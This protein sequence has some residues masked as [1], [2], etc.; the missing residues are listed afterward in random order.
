MITFRRSA[1]ERAASY[2]QSLFCVSLACDTIPGMT[3]Y[4][5]NSLSHKTRSFDPNQTRLHRPDYLDD[6]HRAHRTNASPPPPGMHPRRRR[7]SRLGRYLG[8]LVQTVIGA[9][10]FSF[11]LGLLL[12][13]L[14]II[15][16]PPR[17]TVLI[18]GL[19][20]RP[21]EAMITRSDTII[22]ATVDPAQPYAGML[23]IPR[24]LYVNIPGY[25]MERINA[26]HVLG[27]SSHPGGGPE[28]ATATIEE[29][30][31][32]R[33]DRTLRLNF[34]GFI[35]IV[36]A[37]GGI[38]I[39]VENPIVD[40]EYPTDNYGTIVV[41]FQAGRQ[42]MNG[43]QALQYARIRHGSSDLLRAERQ[44]QVITALA[45]QLENPANWGRLPDVYL[46]ITQNVDTNLTVLDIASM[47]PALI[48]IGPDG[49]DR[50]VL[51]NDYV[52]GATTEAGASILQPQWD[53]IQ[54]LMDEMFRK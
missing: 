41:Q 1:S 26:A 50:H 24:D 42:H 6:T 27:E 37:A 30:F 47:L 4:P 15:A 29:D 38:T 52:V 7:R 44:Q 53:A 20:A 33:I 3:S 48:W 54:G 43:E 36:D 11:L 32:I 8:C 23:S 49:I 21:E 16:P 10:L 9:A 31:G 25:G 12:I 28:L 45:R 40:Y 46:A 2:Q 22:L 17:T 13:V 51:N 5:N 18:L 35:A 19:D 14:Y 34:R 39:D